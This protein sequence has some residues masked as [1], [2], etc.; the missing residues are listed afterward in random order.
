YKRIASARDD[1]ALAQIRAETEDRY[2]RVP[3]SVENLFAYSRLRRLAEQM[4]VVSIDRTPTGV[5]L[6]FGE[7]ARV[8]PEKLMALVGEQAGASF[9]PSGVLRV[10]LPEGERTDLIETARGLLL[11]VRAAD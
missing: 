8:A 3:E 4:G 2:G 5:A 7:R 9:S 6:K 10:E 11:R 1:E